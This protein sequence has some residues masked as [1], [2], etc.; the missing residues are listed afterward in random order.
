MG[1]LTEQWLQANNDK[2]SNIMHKGWL[3]CLK[4]NAFIQMH[5]F[6]PKFEKVRK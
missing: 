4:N 5:I 6:E 2:Y 1:L 3:L